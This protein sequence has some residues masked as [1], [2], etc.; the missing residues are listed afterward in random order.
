MKAP[1]GRVPAAL[2]FADPRLAALLVFIAWRL[3]ARVRTN[4]VGAFKL[5]REVRPSVQALPLVAVVRHRG[6]T[7]KSP[8]PTVRRR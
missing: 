8:V 4:G 5:T 3:Y 7:A 1:C 2:Q 6:A